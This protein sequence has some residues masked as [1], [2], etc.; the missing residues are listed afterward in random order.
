MRTEEDCKESRIRENRTYGLKKGDSL[1]QLLGGSCLYSIALVA[2]IFN[3]FFKQDCTFEPEAYIVPR[4]DVW[5]INNSSTM[6]PS[7]PGMKFMLLQLL[8]R[9][10]QIHQMENNIVFR[11]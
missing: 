11:V 9:L 2:I 8:I 6:Y 7:F 5:N 1:N 10:R 4:W 3:A